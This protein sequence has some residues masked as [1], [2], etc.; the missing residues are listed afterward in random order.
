MSL[1]K[2]MD[3][4][5]YALWNDGIPYADE[6]VYA[7]MKQHTVAALAAPILQDLCLPVELKNA[8]VRTI[9]MQR[10]KYLKTVHVQS[11]LP[12]SVPYVILK[13][14]SAAQYY[15]HPEYR[16]MGDI[17]IMTRR[18]DCSAACDMLLQDG[19]TEVIDNGHSDKER[20]RE[21]V[22]DSIIIEVHAFF[23]SLNDPKCAMYLDDL[24]IGNINPTHVLPDLVNGLVLLEHISQHL[25]HGLGLRQIID[26]MMFV[27]KCLPESEWPTFRIM[28]QNIGLEKLAVTASRMCEMYLGLPHREWCADA[29]E[30]LC[31]ELM[32]YVFECGNFG[33]KWSQEHNASKLLSYART[34][35]SAMKLLQKNGL[36]NWNAAKKHMFLRPFAWIYQ[37]GRFVFKGL[38]QEDAL[39][40]LKAELKEA[41]KRN[42]MFDS[43]GVKQR[44][45]GLVVYKDGR[46]IKK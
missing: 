1:T 9:L 25:E 41:R 35:G 37:A 8:W 2:V 43:L 5:K 32:E 44:S 22:K 39:Y 4:L 34:V 14:T 6:D 19:F 36:E 11:F 20:H 28:A 12:L 24:I 18:E 31:G 13:G 33:N 15:P 46:Y 16:A 40:K 29:D 27:D 26:W 3:L 21:F 10:V 45:R 17:D 42:K 7:E 23:A 38:S 30:K